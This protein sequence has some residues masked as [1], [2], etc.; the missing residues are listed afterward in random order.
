M[1][2]QRIWLM[3][4][5]PG[6]GKSTRAREIQATDPKIMRVGKDAVRNM[7]NGWTKNQDNKG[8]FDSVFEKTVVKAEREVA[9]VLL[10]RGYSVI[11]DDT[12]LSPKHERFFG[13]LANEY[14]ISFK[15]V[16][17]TGLDQ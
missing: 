9:R 3:K 6:S 8:R 11:V 14:G 15:I 5:L 4:G 16:D 1:A 7:F 10:D 13:D 17:L 2:N 12:N